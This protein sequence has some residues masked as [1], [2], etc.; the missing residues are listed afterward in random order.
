MKIMFFVGPA[1]GII[2]HCF[3]LSNLLKQDSHS[4][5][6]VTAPSSREHIDRLNV[7]DLIL[8]HE[9]HEL[10]FDK[11]N[12]TRIPHLRQ[13]CD[14]L[15]LKNCIDLEI[16][17]YNHYKPDLIITKHHYSIVI[18]AKYANI[19]FVTYYTDGAEYLLPNRNP[20]SNRETSDLIKNFYRAANDYKLNFFSNSS[21][22]TS[23]L[24]SPYLNIIRGVP[25]LSSIKNQDYINL[26]KN[27]IFGGLLTFDGNYNNFSFLENFSNF[28]KSIIYVTFGTLCYD[29]ERYYKVINAARSLP[30][31]FF[32][33]STAH[34]KYQASEL[35]PENVKLIDYIPNEYALRKASILIHHGGHGT[36][37]SGF[38]F[39][40]PQLVIPDNIESSAQS[41][42]GEVIESL[43][44][45]KLIQKT[46]FSTE[47]L[48]DTIRK[49][50][51]MIKYRDHAIS[52]SDK[53]NK[54]NL[55]HNQM[56]LNKFR[57]IN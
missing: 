55:Y 46:E 19:P 12:S 31:Y 49:T 13:V 7:N 20:Q 18:S 9:T 52:L 11:S 35:I 33:I 4:V 51:M 23:L 40:V 36:T 41:I 3:A 29:F 39:G 53:I 42:H 43:G 48:V 54:Q 34:F 21:S 5:I 37:L 15:Y 6:F 16:S 1:H 2:N 22:V 44:V 32:L 28:T 27:S 14:Y 57:L 56:L 47:F 24:Q 50:N 25:L 45:G 17:L 30:N 26:P 8:Y 38:Q 10:N